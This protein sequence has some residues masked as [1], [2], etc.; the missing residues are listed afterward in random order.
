MYFTT[1]TSRPSLLIVAL[2]LAAALPLS[3]CWEGWNS[4]QGGDPFDPSSGVDSDG[5][6]IPDS[7]EGE[8]DSD[9]DGVPDYL[10]QDSDGD[11]IPDSI[12]GAD[13][14]DGDGIPDYL[15]LD[16]DDDGIPDSLEGSEDADG[17][18]IPNF[19][20]EDSDG[21]GIPD[22]VEG[23]GDS[24]NDGT[25]DFL[26]TDSDG[27]G[28]PDS[29][30]GT[31]DADGDG[32]P[33]YLDE[34]SDG[35]GI[36]DSEDDDLDGDGIPNSVEGE[37][38]ADGDGIPNL[39]DDD[40]DGD[41]IPD[42]IEGS[43]DADGDGIP[44]FLDLD[45]DDDGYPD[46]VEGYEDID[47]DGLGNFEDADSDGDGIPDSLDTDVDG[48]DISN[49]IEIGGDPANPVDSDGD[50]IPDFFDTD[51][52][53]DGIPDSEETADDFDGDGIPN[54]LDLDSDGDGISDAFE[55]Y[56]DYDGDGDPNFLDLDS[57]G[58]G[59]PDSTDDDYD[60]DGIPNDEEG[61]GDSDGD[62]IPDW[63]DT[64][65]DNDGIPDEDENN[66]DTDPTNSDTDGDGWT[67]LQEQIC[68][69]DPLDPQSTCDGFNGEIPGD[70]SSVVV[71]TYQ[72]QIQ[73]GDVN[74]ILDETGSMQGTLDDVKDNFADVVTQAE[75]LI[76]NLTFGVTSFDDYNFGNMGSGSDKPYHP[77]QQQTTDI[78]AVQTALDDLYAGGGRDW[79]ESTVEALYQA[80][81]GFGYDQNCNGSYDA[82]QDVRPFIS[83]PID[84][85]GGSESGQ[86]EQS[87][88]GPGVAGTGSLGGNGY[89]Q[90]AVPI[91]VYTTDAL[92]RNAFAPFGEGPK[93]TPSP[94][95]SPDAVT[96]ML[97][98]ALA[99]INAKTIGVAARTTD[100]MPAMEQIAQFT[101]SFLDTNENG[102]FDPGIDEW[103]V[104][105][106]TTYNIVD[107]VIQG[108]EEFTSNVTYNITIEAE[109]PA[110]TVLDIDPP[111]HANVFADNVV[112]FT[113]TLEPETSSDVTMFSDTIWVIPTTLYGDGEV[114]LAEVDLI[115]IVSGSP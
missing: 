102:S 111:M 84:A 37:G 18:G 20:D 26:D 93:A 33:N 41:G 4:G 13:D 75:S 96:P 92:V 7:V 98:A 77:Q 58:D 34:D 31:G 72:T 54:Y 8:G 5:D 67:D 10:D 108:I 62:G 80:A 15:D 99:E 74:F 16:S 22:S 14:S 106:S 39:F 28:I 90:G 86:Y 60:G 66:G 21:D 51:S 82:G 69:S 46:A 87:G 107:K 105:S 81:T 100:A 40:S 3:G 71:L 61:N 19:L 38:D 59:E 113:L 65:S 43:G 73:Y 70:A 79:P 110:G 55:G 23:S 115:F 68:G 42:S 114:I 12:E 2:L 52:D 63:A 45:S 35:D 101:D 36:P 56:D 88:W 104:Y 109:A 32:I 76:P 78:G 83:S 103:L 53:G 9:G 49:E 11:G 94:G 1:A 91:L 50:G 89:R 29:V 24:D 30:E 97:L 47:G 57:D 95:C 112:N 27:D 17:D 85:F 48:D 6:G 25:P 64:D 44:N